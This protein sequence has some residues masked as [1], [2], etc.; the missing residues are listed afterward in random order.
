MKHQCGISEV[1]SIA[2]NHKIEIKRAANTPDPIPNLR[3]VIG[4]IKGNKIAPATGVKA[5]NNF[6]IINSPNCGKNQNHS[7][8]G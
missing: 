4:T 5:T 6:N 7:L 1:L 2:A 8:W 3:I